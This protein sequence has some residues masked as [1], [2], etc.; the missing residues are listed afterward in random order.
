MENGNGKVGWLWEMKPEGGSNANILLQF[1]LIE[2]D[3]EEEE[4]V[5]PPVRKLHSIHFVK[6]F[7]PGYFQQ[8]SGPKMKNDSSLL[9]KDHHPSLIAPSTGSNA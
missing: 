8:P 2:E 4:C 5:G 9:P 3:D 7:G 6:L 1:N